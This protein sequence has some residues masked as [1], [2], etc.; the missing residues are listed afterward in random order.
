MYIKWDTQS[1]IS[2]LILLHHLL[3]TLNNQILSLLLLGQAKASSTLIITMA[4]TWSIGIFTLV[5]IYP[6]FIAPWLPRFMY[7]LNFIHSDYIDVVH[8]CDEQLP[9]LL[10]QGAIHYLPCRL[11]TKIYVG[12]YVQSHGTN[13]LGL[14][15]E[16]SCSGST[17]YMYHRACVKCLPIDQ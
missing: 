2:P 11:S 16:Q 7:T 17:K 12:K 8:V 5:T 9:S 3:T 13:R 4:P 15:R 1:L 6:M 10:K 14:L